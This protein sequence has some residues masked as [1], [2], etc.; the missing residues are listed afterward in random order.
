ML[1]VSIHEIKGGAKATVTAAVGCV[2]AELRSLNRRTPR[3]GSSAPMPSFKGRS[4]AIT[5][6]VW[7]VRRFSMENLKSTFYQLAIAA[8]LN[9]DE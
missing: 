6:N 3:S 2:F 5:H 8:Y 7:S 1:K 4:F 9:T